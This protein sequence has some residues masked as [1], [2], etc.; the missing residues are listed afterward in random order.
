MLLY[1]NKVF[2]NAEPPKYYDLTFSIRREI[3]SSEKRKMKTIHLSNSSLKI[4]LLISLV[5]R[6]KHLKESKYF[7]CVC[8]RCCD[9]TENGTHF[10]TILCARCGDN[11]DN[12]SKGH[13]TS[14]DPKDFL[15]DWRCDSCGVKTPGCE[16]EELV[17]LLE[18]EVAQLPTTKVESCCFL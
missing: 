1:A 11:K 4:I 17:D 14:I 5:F 10:S 3:H 6:R 2:A 9:P 8:K 16:I 12:R 13:V 7:E 15:A 18:R